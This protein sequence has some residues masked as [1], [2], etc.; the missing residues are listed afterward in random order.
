M[1][2]G[3]GP[4]IGFDAF[5]RI[6]SQDATQKRRKEPCRITSRVPKLICEV[7]PLLAQGCIVRRKAALRLLTYVLA[8]FLGLLAGRITTAALLFTEIGWRATWIEVGSWGPSRQPE[9]T[10]MRQGIGVA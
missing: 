9:A 2:W 7:A 5:N 10:T 1:Q 6:T 3:S 8:A 4:V